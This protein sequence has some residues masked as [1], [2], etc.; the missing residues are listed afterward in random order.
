MKTKTKAILKHIFIP[1]GFGI[2]IGLISLLFIDLEHSSFWNLILEEFIY[3]IILSYVFWRGNELII[4]NLNSRYSW[5]KETRKLITLH[6]V[7]VFTYNILVIL[8][9][10]LY[11]W[12]IVFHKSDMHHFLKTFR[13][14]FYMCLSITLMVTLFSYA[15]NFLKQLKISANK[16]EQLKRES[17][18][19][20]YEALKNQVNPHF[21][22]NSLNV[23]TSLIEKD[24]DASVNYVKQLS[25]VMRYVLE[26]TTSEL[27]TIATELKF[28]DSF[29]YLLKIRFGENFRLTLDVSDK[30]F[31]IV[32]VALQILIENAVKHNE[33]STENPLNV[34]ITE[35]NDY[36]IVQNTIQLR[37][38]LPES[39]HIGLKSLQ[40]QYKFLS[41][42][43]LE[44]TN[45]GGLFTVKIPKI[46]QTA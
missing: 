17:I 32:P 1:V 34:T 29:V 11:L 16:E 40:F 4:K 27:V 13:G 26:Q 8:I 38:Y 12:F 2:L 14:G 30:S 46:K 3:S 15:Y 43:Q 6:I 25:E 41:G 9:F 31:L 45:I 33:I 36:L 23:L 7:Q 10:Y 22:F 19:L 18:T 39:N 44:I 24:K 5:I 37:N 42:K 35:D 28:I 20:Q 21:L